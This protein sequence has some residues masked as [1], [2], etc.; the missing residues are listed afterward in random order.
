MKQPGENLN[1]AHRRTF[2]PVA[3]LERLLPS[4]WWRTLFNSLYLKTDGDVVENDGNT[5]RDVSALVRILNLEPNDRILD[6]CCG[7]GRHTIELARR[8][9]AHVTG[10]DRSRYLIRLAR[11]RAGQAGVG[12]GFHEGDARKLRFPADSFHV[13]LVLGNSFGYFE[14]EEEDLDVLLSLHRVLRSLGSLALDLADG[15]WMRQSFERRSWE[16][17]DEQQFVCRERALSEDSA[18]LITREV[19]VHAEKGVLADQFYAER[20]YSRD[21]LQDLLGAAGFIQVRMHQEIETE[22]SRGQDL[23]MMGKRILLT[24]TVPQKPPQRGKVKRTTPTEVT[25]LLGDPRLPDPV[26]RNGAFNPEDLDTVQRLKTA[27]AELGEYRF[28]YLDNH[29][30]LQS[31]LRSA[32]PRLV[33]NLC[34]EGWNNDAFLELHVPALLEMMGV[35]YTGAGPA[36]LAHCYNKSLVRA[37]AASLD[38]PVPLETFFSPDDLAAHLPSVF[39]AL[40]KP[41]FG[42]SSIGI[43]MDALV[44]SPESLIAYMAKL[45]ETL[46]GRPV[47]IQEYLEGPEYSLTLLGNPGFALTP[48]PI[49]EVDYSGLPAGLPPILGYESKWLP[50]SP[51]WAKI[52]YMEATMDEDL[53][54]SLIDASTL[55]FERLACRDYA[56]FDFRTDAQGEVK[57]LE[58]NPNPG[59]CWDGKFNIMAGL[60]GMRYADLLRRILESAQE[61]TEMSA[62][63][64]TFGA[65]P[66]DS[67]SGQA[68][69]RRTSTPSIPAP[70]A[71]N[72]SSIKSSPR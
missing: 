32:P 26:K 40:V 43:T 68:S 64:R 53:K 69:S 63:D 19:V 41:N 14:K 61:R 6:L 72:T 23:G 2:G 62:N 38:I 24:A 58:V 36:C 37:V 49:L 47:L 20:L 35:P 51:Y 3:D 50:D 67:P 59:W 65:S 11:K 4:C 1:P 45:K 39:P 33:F 48:L 56:R 29:S 71:P 42:D 8:G 60:A 34:D 46:P 28:A 30:S 55:L 22:S 54:R 5:A 16:W 10:L 7:Q 17:I 12:A 27:L 13:A 31:D 70:R 52:G 66:S 57:L 18:R 44:D 21:R 15:E 25:V 9:F